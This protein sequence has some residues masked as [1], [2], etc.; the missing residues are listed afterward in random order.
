MGALKKETGVK[1]FKPLLTP[2]DLSTLMQKPRRYVLGLIKRRQIKG[3]RFGGN[4]WRVDPEEWIRFKT[5]AETAGGVDGF[6]H[7][8]ASGG[9]RKGMFGFKPQNKNPNERPQ[10][11]P[12]SEYPEGSE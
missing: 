2:D 12:Q 8:R 9:I 7:A 1:G 10:N 11:E 3:I 5:A 6:R 4:S